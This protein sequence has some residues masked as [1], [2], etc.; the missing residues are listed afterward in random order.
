MSNTPKLIPELNAEWKVVRRLADAILECID[1]AVEQL[2]DE[3]ELPDDE[4][5]IGDLADRLHSLAMT[6][7][8]PD[9]A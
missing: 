1:N 6:G 7:K 4:D 8:E 5:A 3:Y 2:A 9:D